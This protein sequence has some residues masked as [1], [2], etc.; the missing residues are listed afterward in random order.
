M[1]KRKKKIEPSDFYFLVAL[2]KFII[3][4]IVPPVFV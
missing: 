4:W 1:Q 2:L 3:Q